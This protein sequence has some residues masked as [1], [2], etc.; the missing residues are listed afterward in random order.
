MIAFTL[1]LASQALTKG[2]GKV[3]NLPSG[4]TIDSGPIIWKSTLKQL[5]YD[6]FL[7]I[8][9][10]E[11]PLGSL[12]LAPPK[13][14]V[15]KW[16]GTLDVSTQ[17]PYA[18]SSCSQMDF[19]EVLGG[20]EDCLHLHV[21][22]PENDGKSSMMPVMVWIHGGGFFAGSADP[23]FYGPDHIMDYD[24]ILVAINYRVGPLGFMTFENPVL[25]GN[26]GMRDQMAALTWVQQNIAAFGGDPDKVTIF[27]ESAGSM[28]VLYLTVS[29]LAKG[30]FTGAIAQS[31]S[32]ISSYTHWD[33]KPSL[34]TR[35]LSND[36][37]CENHQTD[38]E[39][40]Q[41]LRSLDHM[42]FAS[43]TKNFLHYP[44]IGPSVWMPYVDGHFSSEPVLPD[45]PET[46]LESGRYNQVPIIIG[47]NS[48]EGALNMVGFL[49]GR[50]DFEEVDSRWNTELGPLILF[51]RSL[52]ETMP[53]DVAWAKKIREF[54]FGGSDA[55]IGSGTIKEFIKLAGDH[56]FYGGTEQT[57]RLLATTSTKPVYRY[58]YSHV[59]TWT[60]VDVFLLNSWQ[61]SL[62]IAANYILGIELY[63]HELGVCHSDELFAMFQP[64]LL[65]ISSLQT[66]EDKLVSKR[67]LTYWTNFAKSGNPNNG[68]EVEV[69]WKPSGKPSFLYLDINSGNDLSMDYDE[70]HRKRTDLWLTIQADVRRYR[71][72]LSDKPPLTSEDLLKH[73][74]INNRNEL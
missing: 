9:Y 71:N 61:Y 37:G 24:V 23:S 17:G 5:P 20:Q 58:M 12:R 48:D 31:G 19:H 72:F 49:D 33:K 2:H 73:K 74:P 6:A 27:G 3:I 62:K 32:F 46:L 7:G 21:Y 69:E 11:P 15:T 44:W 28:A 52:D 13:A 30:L 42:T 59:G 41:C 40:L 56:M 4:G 64:H 54:Y 26:L 38:E 36:L 18:N 57:V 51:H 43:A 60:A 1:L 68:M 22:V 10:A 39:L 55:K 16:P 8:P 50:A 53:E 70:D 34:Y 35:R 45:D 63:N 65:P 14:L 29:P 67:V 47:T 25:E 66:E